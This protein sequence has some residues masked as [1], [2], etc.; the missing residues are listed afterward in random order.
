VD[1]PI[2]EIANILE[3]R[4][5][6]RV[7]VLEGDKLVGIVTRANLLQA[8]AA[9]APEPAES[10]TRADQE[11]R[12]AVL[13]EISAQPWA[14][15]FLHNNVIVEDGVVS[16]WGF[17]SNEEQRKALLVAAHNIPGV[18]DVE[19]HLEYHMFAAGLNFMVRA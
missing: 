19:D 15:S 6:K 16:L 4:H 11:I 12:E 1:T 8:L 14:G 17:V 18:R 9:R 10:S 5:I 7:P 2:P 13:R 3:S